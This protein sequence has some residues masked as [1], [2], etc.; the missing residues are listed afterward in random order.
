MFCPNVEVVASKMLIA[1]VGSELLATTPVHVGAAHAPTGAAHANA[2]TTAERTNTDRILLPH[3]SPAPFIA[4]M[5][6][7]KTEIQPLAPEQS[8]QYQCTVLRASADLTRLRAT[9]RGQ[10]S[11]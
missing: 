1:S 10:R 11:H 3:I 5:L 8:P 2:I 4:L 7:P 6:V 9:A